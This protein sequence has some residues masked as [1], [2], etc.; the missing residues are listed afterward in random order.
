MVKK[1]IVVLAEGFEE[2]EAVTIIDIL[3]RAGIGVTVASLDD[4]KVQGSHGVTVLADIELEKAG[5]DFD[6]CVLPGGMPGSTHLA[7]SKTVQDLIEKMNREKKIVAAICASPSL[8]LAP[9]GVLN[10]KKA[11][12]YPGMQTHFRQD[13]AYKTDDVV[14]DGNIITSR[15]PATAIL[16]SL[17]IVEKLIGKETA[18]KVK[19]ATLAG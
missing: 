12:C 19:K 15:G 7:T 4:L 8:A 9:L 10:N 16:F 11:T 13:T 5:S 3:R 1:A 14:I 6:A 2:I 17:A 18:E